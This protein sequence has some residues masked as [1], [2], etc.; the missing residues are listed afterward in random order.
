MSYSG[1]DVDIFVFTYNRSDLIAQTIE[2]LLLQ[3]ESGIKIHV[4]DNASTDST[5]DIVKHFESQGVLYFR[6]EV[7]TGWYGNLERAKLLAHRSWTMLFHDDDLLHPSYCEWALRQINANRHIDLLISTLS[8]ESQPD[9]IWPTWANG[10]P[11]LCKNVNEL[12]AIFYSG[13]PVSFAS[14]IYRTKKLRS[15]KW[16]EIEYGKI[17]DRPFLMKFL[18]NQGQAIVFRHPLIKYR[19]HSNQDSHNSETGPYVSQLSSLHALYLKYLGCN[20]FNF[21]GRVFLRNNYKFLRDEYKRL[22]SVDKRQFVSFGDYWKFIYAGKGATIS[23]RFVGIFIHLLNPKGIIQMLFFSKRKIKEI[24]PKFLIKKILEI[25]GERVQPMKIIE[26]MEVDFALSRVYNQRKIKVLDI[27]SHHG[28]FI[29]I[30]GSFNHFHE[31]DVYCVEPLDQNQKKI[32]NKKR[33]YRNVSVNILPVGVSEISEVKKFYLGD[34]DTLFTC[35]ESWRNEF[36]EYF[37]I[38]TEHVINCLSV[39]DLVRTYNLPKSDFDFIKIDVEGHDLN[40]IKSFC[41]SQI[42]SRVVMFEVSKDVT[43]VQEAVDLLKKKGFHE[44]VLFGRIGIPTTFLGEYEG[45]TQL[46]TLFSSGRISC[47]NIVCFR[48]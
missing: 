37:K 43:S 15:F 44:F 36:K 47:G 7:N 42:N 28:E 1:K 6:G 26:H 10:N 46:E 30:M 19:L 3:T 8:F 9:N 12:A 21:P 13:L 38:F 17:V 11:A 29:D 4:L 40:V 23:S 34:A 35:N 18:E 33:K 5:P 41:D 27:G 14:A 48:N 22:A 20:P 25:N 2:N 24:I 39:D 45:V 16:F 32:E 31:W